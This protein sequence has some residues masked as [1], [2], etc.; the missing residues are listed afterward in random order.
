MKTKYLL[1]FLFVAFAVVTVFCC[2][3]RRDP[4]PA[5]CRLISTIDQVVEAN[6]RLTDEMQR[7]FTYTNA[8]LTSIAERSQDQEA[9]FL[10]EYAN[11]RA[12]RAVGGTASIEI[13]YLPTATQPSSATLS[14]GGQLMSRFAMEYTSAGGMSRI[15]ESR[16]VLPSNSQTTE[17]AFTFTYDNAGNLATERARFSLRGGVV[18]EQETDYTV[19]PTPSPYAR[20]PERALLTVIAL[21]QAVETRPGQFWHINLPVAHKSYNVTGSG[22]RSSLRDS[23]TFVTNYDTDGKLISQDQTAFLH[24]VGATDPITKRNRQTYSYQCD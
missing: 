1:R 24:Q 23:S 11:G 9:G 4:E 19:V 15:T 2:Q 21:S 20:F 5:V 10:V 12:V 22:S 18:V 7:T 14:R 17:R 3:Q 16:N 13:G 8:V 6:G